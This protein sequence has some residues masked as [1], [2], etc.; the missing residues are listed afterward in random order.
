MTKAKSSLGFKPTSD[1][2]VLFRIIEKQQ[3]MIEELMEAS[4][5]F[6]QQHL[7]MQL[8]RIQAE[9]AIQTHTPMPSNVLEEESAE[10]EEETE[11]AE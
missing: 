2:E 8:T 9:V 4:S 11:N 1:T 6:I 10:S 5:C 7:S 3:K